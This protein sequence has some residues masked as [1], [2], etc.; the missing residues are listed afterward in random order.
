LVLYVPAAVDVALLRWPLEGDRRDELAAEGL[1]RLLLVEEGASPIPVDCL[2]DWV[3]IPAADDEVQARV[4]SLRLRAEQHRP[5]V[6]VLDEFGMLRFGAQW[7][8]LAPVEARLTRAL[9]ERMGAVVSREALARAGWP[10]GAPGRNALDVHVLRMRRRLAP[11]GLAIHTVR[12]RGYLLDAADVI[13]RSH[14]G[15]GSE[16]AAS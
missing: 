7:T 6:P 9:V 10:G 14:I 15:N 13:Q 12:S 2:E 5:Q 4:A 16:T 3:R 8:S 11:L 1:P